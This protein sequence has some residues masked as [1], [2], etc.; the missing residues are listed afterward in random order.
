M[1][2]LVPEIRFKGFTDDW[3]QRKLGDI[4]SNLKS[5][6]SRMLSND[7]IGL[8]V[9]RANNVVDGK[10]DMENDVKYWYALDPQG[11]QTSNYF[12]RKD[13]ILINFINSESRM[14]TAAIVTETPNRDTIYTTNILNLRTNEYS[15]PYFVYTLTFTKKYQD[16]ISIITK[17]AVSQA[18]FTTVDF[19][20]YEFR[21]PSVYEQTAIGNFFRTLD[22]TISLYNQKLDTLKKLKK[23][24][25]QQM[26]PQM[27]DSVP[28]ARFSG[29]TESWKFEKLGKYTSITT[30]KLDANAMVEDGEYDFFTS[31][32]KKYKIDKPAFTGP[33]ITIAGNGAT[34]GYMHF[35]D[36]N[37]NA[38][39]RTY[40]LT[41][42]Q[43]DRRFLFPEIGNRLPKKIAVEA[44]AGNIP[45]IVMEMLTDLKVW[46]PSDIKEQ[47]AIGT[48]FFNLDEQI[49]LQSQKLEQ[50]KQLKSAYL[51][52]MFVQISF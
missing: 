14:G 9:V 15:I 48:F 45:Y 13:D 49:A 26:F 18:S 34:V 44:R 4:I 41:S 40:V 33:A 11:A 6:L 19:K 36:G 20:N 29:F 35:A 8:P 39:Q 23:G 51:Q 50:L 17:P 47:T 31:G 10:F 3:V 1:R 27:G 16:Y 32:I 46:I 12:I 25:L 2:G 28:R 21:C 42:F 5:G 7:D 37:F 24:Y 22:N 38:Y 30:G 43:V 52:K